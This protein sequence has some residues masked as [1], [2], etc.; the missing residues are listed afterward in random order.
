MGIVGQAGDQ[1]VLERVA[2]LCLVVMQKLDL[3]FGHIHPRR[4]VALA[5]FAAYTEVK[6]LVDDFACQRVLGFHPVELT[7]ERQP[8]RVGPPPRRVLF[9]PRDAVAGAHGACIKL[10]AVAVVVAHLHGFGK[11]LRCVTACAG[12]A[13]QLGYRIVLDIPGTPVKRGFNRYDLV[14]GRI[15][16]QPRV[17]H[18]GRVDD[19]LRAQQVKRVQVV[20]DLRKSVVDHWPK[21]PLDPLA[22][23]QTVAMLAA[24][25]A[26]VVPHQL[27]RFFGNRAHLASAFPAHV[28]NR[29]HMECSYRCVGI[30]GAF[31]AV[32]FEDAGQRA[33]VFGQ[34]RQRY[35]AVFNKTH[36][37]AVAL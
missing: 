36:R 13:G 19:A 8:Q 14:A 10:A 24:V 28:Q 20:F 30:P 11:A 34:M 32:F 6:G 5:A 29:P 17:V 21:L 23:A 33:G 2:V 12:C 22:P 7:A 35:G 1:F 16:H 37:L 31:A 15:A 9:V 4:A 27:G 18:F 3:H 26:F 25:G